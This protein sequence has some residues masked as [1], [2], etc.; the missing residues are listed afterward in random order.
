MQDMPFSVSL[1]PPYVQDIKLGRDRI[2]DS[3]HDAGLFP[4]LIKGLHVR[5]YLF[6]GSPSPSL[7]ITYGI[8]LTVA[9]F[10][11]TSRTWGLF[12]LILL[13]FFYD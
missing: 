10:H 3:F 8:D 11:Q 9:S 6:Y 5:N 7:R 2:E 4:T 12:V 13:V 1:S